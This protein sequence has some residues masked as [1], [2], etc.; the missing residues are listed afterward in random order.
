M[1][2]RK[3]VNGFH[4]LIANLA[5]GSRGRNLELS[6]PAQKFTHIPNRLQFGYVGLQEDSIQ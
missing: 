4:I 2:L 3:A 5:K 1:L 6:L